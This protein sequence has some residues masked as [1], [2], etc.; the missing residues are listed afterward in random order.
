MDC[1]RLAQLIL[2][3]RPWIN[4]SGRFWGDWSN[5]RPL[6]Q[7]SDLRRES[8]SWGNKAEN[9]IWWHGLSHWAKLSQTAM[10]GISPCVCPPFFSFIFCYS[11]LSFPSVFLP[12]FPY[13]GLTHSLMHAR[14]HK[15][16][17]IHK[18]ISCESCLAMTLTSLQSLL[19]SFTAEITSFCLEEYRVSYLFSCLHT[20]NSP[21]PLCLFL[22]STPTS[23]HPFVFPIYQPTPEYTHKHTHI[24]RW[25]SG[26]LCTDGYGSIALGKRITLSTFCWIADVM[27]IHSTA[28]AIDGAELAALMNR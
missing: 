27:S 15:Q 25:F 5:V 10:V 26:L 13:I 1:E 12:S 19:G 23:V 8:F 17:H 16:L 2:K 22:L 3:P 18:V 7:E 21:I 24:Y 6:I 28:V 4:I 11:A 9:L 14:T 20:C